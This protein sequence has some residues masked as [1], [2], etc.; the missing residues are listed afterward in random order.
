MQTNKHSITSQIILSLVVT[1]I[2]ILLFGTVFHLWYTLNH[3]KHTLKAQ[4]ALEAQLIA[5]MTAASLAFLDIKGMNEQLHYLKNNPD[6]LS[7]VVYDTQ[8]MPLAYYSPTD[9][10]S[11]S[12][13]MPPV[14][15]AYHST[16]WKP[17][18]F[19]NL[20]T[21]IEIK[22]REQILGYLSIERKSDR[23]S[24]FLLNMLSS[25]AL[26]SL[27]LLALVY[28]M[29]RHLSKKI[30]QPVLDLSN[31][32]QEIADSSDYSIRVSYAS[33]NEITSLYR[34]FNHLLNET[35]SLTTQLEARVALRT[36][37]L[38]DSL[39]ALQKTQL[40]MVQSE[41]MAALGNLVSGVAHEVN[42]PLGNAI[43]GGSIILKESK[44]L[45][46]LMETGTLK[47]ST[48]EQGLQILNETS[49]LLLKS[50]T[51]AAD[52]I[53]SFKRISVDQGAED[54]REF[55][56]YEYLQE[57]LLTFHNNLKKVPVT[58]NLSGDHKLSLKSYPGVYAQILTNFIQ[59]SLLHGFNDQ[60]SDPTITI[61]YHIESDNLVLTYTDNGQ[62]MDDNMRTIAFE[63]FTTTKRNT[64]GSGLG[65]NI[66][67]NLVTQ[68]LNGTI[69]LKS[70]PAKGTTFTIT[71]PLSA[72][73]NR[74]KPIKDEK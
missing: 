45:L 29:A 22:E 39:D 58:V 73:E 56:L 71:L 32:A 12:A 27:I 24:K 53:R 50:L 7:I 61:D 36:K 10:K 17:W 62:G 55:N 34:S 49:N 38:Q 60:T 25:L 30:L 14:Q 70:E 64:G 43:T 52:L 66:I 42:T 4:S 16:T 65:L 35:Q 6:I 37:E 51:Q 68:K 33:D 54:M 72:P 9:Q 15:N 1:S 3:E 13:T 57:I 40:Q 63:P 28:G 41:K 11:I 47:K 74:T 8:K 46:S 67:Y 44:N 26:F 19:G 5:D 2:A 18:I 20:T 69:T 23:I 59:N 21:T 31:T 48:M